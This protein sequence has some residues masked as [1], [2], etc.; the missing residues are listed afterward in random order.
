MATLRKR[1]P[2]LKQWLARARWQSV[3]WARMASAQALIACT[4]LLLAAL[5]TWHSF[6]MQ[7]QR[8]QLQLQWQE[9]Q[10]KR[11]AQANKPQIDTASADLARQLV[12]F[13]GFLP[14]HDAIPDQVK[15]LLA[16]ADKHGLQL[17]QGDYKALPQPNT[18]MLRYQII[19]PVKADYPRIIN[20]LQS[21]LQEMPSLTLESM[22][23][24]RTSIDA[25]EVEARL[26]LVIFVQNKRPKSRVQHE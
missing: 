11:I 17:A 4:L 24:K 21:A 20:F 16:S 2:P 8:Q 19:L 7:Q 14:S 6:A 26:Q 10:T 12:Q 25:G 5:L 1:P 23:L 13:Y 18:A 3:R 9:Q 22:Q 15:R